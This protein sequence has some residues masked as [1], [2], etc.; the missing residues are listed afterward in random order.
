MR[1][2]SAGGSGTLS[3][4]TVNTVSTGTSGGVVATGT[5]GAGLYGY[6]SEYYDEGAEESEA[7]VD[8]VGRNGDEQPSESVRRGPGVH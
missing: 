5:T 1:Q 4:G 7:S 8:G 6:G 2:T 3:G